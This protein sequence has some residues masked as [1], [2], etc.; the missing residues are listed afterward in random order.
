MAMEAELTLLLEKLQL[1]ALAAP[2]AHFA[3]VFLAHTSPGRI[4]CM[5]WD[6]RK[7][8]SRSTLIM[9]VCQAMGMQGNGH[10]LG[11]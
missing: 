4:R 1:Q 10:A 8:S 11:Q 6:K 2:R 7:C 5:P 9:T 3:P